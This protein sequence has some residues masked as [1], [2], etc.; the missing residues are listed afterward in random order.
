MI[1][2]AKGYA[3]C[4]GG[5]ITRYLHARNPGTSDGSPSTTVPLAELR[6]FRTSTAVEPV[7]TEILL[8]V[9]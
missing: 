5:R 1:Y 2:D 6:D 3:A 8:G 7:G 9:L 4:V